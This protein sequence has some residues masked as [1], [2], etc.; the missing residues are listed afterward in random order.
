MADVQAKEQSVTKVPMIYVCGGK[1]YFH[2][3]E[4]TK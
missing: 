3:T 1:T 4:V 2:N